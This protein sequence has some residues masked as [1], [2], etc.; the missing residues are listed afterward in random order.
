MASR[1]EIGKKVRLER[2]A[3]GEAAKQLDCAINWL[4]INWI[5]TGCMKCYDYIY[6]KFVSTDDINKVK[7]IQK[8]YMTA[9]DASKLLGMHRTHI[10]N[11]KAQGK[12]NSVSF[13]ESN[14]INLYRRKDVLSLLKQKK[15]R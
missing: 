12:I 8:E 10:I 14:P 2:R 1:V 15:L 9:I 5:R 7:M 11:L 3:L 6:W 4:H 13:G